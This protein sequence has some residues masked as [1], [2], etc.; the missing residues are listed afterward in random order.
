MGMIMGK[1]LHDKEERNL[2]QENYLRK[3]RKKTKN[4]LKSGR[5]ENP[6]KEKKVERWHRN[7]ITSRT[8][9]IEEF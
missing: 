7:T 3:K 6:K 8:L 4:N 1:R 5:E 9:K 2:I